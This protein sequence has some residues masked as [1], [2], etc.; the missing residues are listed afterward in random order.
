MI[1]QKSFCTFKTVNQLH[2]CFIRLSGFLMKNVVQSVLAGGGV[3]VGNQQNEQAKKN[4][5]RDG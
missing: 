2:P 5:Q 4:G 1:F 3:N